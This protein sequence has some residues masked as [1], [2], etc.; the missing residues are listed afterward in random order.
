MNVEDIPRVQA[1]AHGFILATRM[2]PELWGL[3]DDWDFEDGE[4]EPYEEDYD[5]EDVASGDKEIA[6]GFAVVMGVAFP[7]RIPELFND[8]AGNPVTHGKKGPSLEATLFTLLPDAVASLQEY[9]NSA[10]D[11]KGGG[12]C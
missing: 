7:E 2:F 10:R 12:K 11:G 5:E 4:D 6:A 9:A 8:G 1:W 3:E